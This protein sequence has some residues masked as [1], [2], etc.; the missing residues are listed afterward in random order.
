M[1]RLEFVNVQPGGLWVI[2]PGV[3]QR[4]NVVRE[5]GLY[6]IGAPPG[7]LQFSRT[8]LGFFGIPEDGVACLKC[9]C[10][11]TAEEPLLSVVKPFC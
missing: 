11:F 4:N 3:N 6:L 1:I 8:D 7:K 10:L 5:G 9:F 2:K